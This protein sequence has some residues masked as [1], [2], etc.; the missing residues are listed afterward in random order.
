MKRLFISAL[1]LIVALSKQAL[2][3]D[4]VLIA[5]SMGDV[6]VELDK[7]KAPVTVANFLRYVN[8][9]YYS[10][11]TFHRVMMGFMIQGGGFTPGMNQKF[12]GLMR[13]IKSE[14]DNGLSNVTGTIA[15][16][17]TRNPDSATSQF[18]IN[19]ATNHFL[20]DGV[21]G[22]GY[23]VFGKVVE[24]MDVVLA[25]SRVPVGRVG[26]HGNVPDEH[27]MINEMRVLEEPAAH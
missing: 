5:T 27:I 18:F 12:E 8:N 23:T 24:G 3:D 26:P 14:A 21:R 9:G 19:V 17:R 13:P 15:M 6:I 16:A 22:P 7:Q 2:A 11:T 1:F 4:R 10:G 25:I 20:N